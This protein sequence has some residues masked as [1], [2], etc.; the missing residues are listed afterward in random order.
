MNFIKNDFLDIQAMIKGNWKNLTFYFW[1]FIFLPFFKW[2]LLLYICIYFVQTIVFWV[3][4]LIYKTPVF[5]IK[6]KWS[7]KFL[8]DFIPIQNLLILHT[9]LTSSTDKK[10]VFV[11]VLF[12]YLF[13][14]IFGIGL[15]TLKTC[16]SFYDEMLKEFYWA[17]IKH[18]RLRLA[19]L[20]KF[21]Q[22]T[23]LNTLQKEFFIIPWNIPD[24]VTLEKNKF[25][26]TILIKKL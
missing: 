25:K 16:I 26:K 4:L 5:K 14:T 7:A 18:K 3:K 24:Q 12:R 22:N 10:E 20:I 13:L 17:E 23:L 21:A 9:L 2:I 19:I 6:V 11:S 15:K 1:L 8:F